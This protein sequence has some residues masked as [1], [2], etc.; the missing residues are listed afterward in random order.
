MAGEVCLDRS[1]SVENCVPLGS[2]PF[3][4]RTHKRGQWHLGT[5]SLVWGTAAAVSGGGAV[6]AAKL[7]M[8]LAHIQACAELPTFSANFS[9]N[10][11]KLELLYLCLYLALACYFLKLLR[12]RVG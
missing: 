3:V 2:T 11:V 4:G 5:A 10:A 7:D 12:F 6:R 1:H 8:P 9:F